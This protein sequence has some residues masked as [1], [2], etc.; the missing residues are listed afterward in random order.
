M[1][2]SPL[3]LLSGFLR[4]PYK[5]LQPACARARACAWPN[6]LMILIILLSGRPSWFFVADI[7]RARA[8]LCLY[9]ACIRS[10][11]PSVLRAQRVWPAIRERHE[12]CSRVEQ[13]SSVPGSHLLSNVIAPNRH[14]LGAVDGRQVRAMR[15]PRHGRHCCPVCAVK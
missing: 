7:N 14:R 6:Q 10:F 12:R 11:I 15:M 9:H 5:A 3:P 4:R 2:S 13:Q 8:R 1:Y